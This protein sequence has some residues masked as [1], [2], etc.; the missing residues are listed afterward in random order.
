MKKA[1]L[2]LLALTLLMSACKKHTDLKEIHFSILGD[3]FSAFK[4][5]VDP[6]SNDAWYCPPPNNNINVTQVEQMWW[7]K[8]A[9]EMGW[10]LDKNN[11]FSG[12]LICNFWGYNAGPYYSPHSFIRRMDN[13]GDPDVIFIFGGTNDVWNGAYY[14]DF[15]YSDWTERQL[16]EYRPALA[17]LFENLKQL[18][19]KAIVYLMID[20]SLTDY[21][22]TGQ[23]FVESAHTIA[24]HYG[25]DCID[26]HDIHKKWA[27]PDAEGQNDIAEQ[28][29]DYLENEFF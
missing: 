22:H 21:D 15:V 9:T 3:S 11:S 25:I 23:I 16:E 17:Y 18:Y 2:V 7:H 12:S 8:V 24:R 1:T 6:D 20:T 28:V 4:G 27:H 13:L 14:G 5:Y 10:I 26:L 19:P 29:I